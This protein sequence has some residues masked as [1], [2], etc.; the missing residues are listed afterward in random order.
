MGL[1]LS[2]MQGSSPSVRGATCFGCQWGIAPAPVGSRCAAHPGSQGGPLV[3]LAGL[4]ATRPGR[5]LLGS[6]RHSSITSSE[7]EGHP[8]LIFLP[9]PLLSYSQL[10]KGGEKCFWTLAD[11]L[12]YHLLYNFSVRQEPKFSSLENASEIFLSKL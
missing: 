10:G 5:L 2:V 3:G 6:G 12:L 7:H 11:V 4:P 9:A 1:L 8:F